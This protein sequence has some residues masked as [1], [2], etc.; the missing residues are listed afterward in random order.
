V[1]PVSKQE[2]TKETTEVTSTEGNR[3][4]PITPLEGTPSISQ[5][6]GLERQLSL[7]VSSF[8]IPADKDQDIKERYREIKAR[9]EK[10]KVQTYAQYLKMTPTN[11]T[12]LMSDFDIK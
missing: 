3:S 11:Q 7:E 5:T 12:R 4:M 8:R 10:L 6:Q 1:N 9:N 2:H